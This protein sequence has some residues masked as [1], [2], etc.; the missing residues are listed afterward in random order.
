M[1]WEDLEP[2]DVLEY[3][4]EYKGTVAKN[5]AGYLMSGKYFTVEKIS[6]S[7]GL[8]FINFC[9]CGPSC[10]IIRKDDGSDDDEIYRFP[11]FKIVKLAKEG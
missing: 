5:L 3:T 4:E 7:S 2:G 9:E 8:I 1:K 6:L 11:A 10:F